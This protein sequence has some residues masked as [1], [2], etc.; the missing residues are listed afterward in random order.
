MRTL[1]VFWKPHETGTQT[2]TNVCAKVQ[3]ASKS[4]R[5]WAACIVHANKLEVLKARTCKS[6]RLEILR[7]GN[8]QDQ[9]LSVSLS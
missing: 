7:K 8:K 1:L 5:W 2:K 6:E 3:P 4:D 9:V